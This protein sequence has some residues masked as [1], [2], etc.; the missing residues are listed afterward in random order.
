MENQAQTEVPATSE[1]QTAASP[2]LTITD[3]TNLRSI[4][5]VAVRRGAFQAAEI[6]SVGAAYDRL[7]SFLNAVAPAAAE[8]QPA[9]AQ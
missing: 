4:V 8:E 5:D 3:L 9:D 1:E 2:E 7:N 6:S